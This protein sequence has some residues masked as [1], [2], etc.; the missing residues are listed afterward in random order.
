MRGAASQN[1][2][3]M[4]LKMMEKI[5]GVAGNCWRTGDQSTA[6]QKMYFRPETRG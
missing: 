4:L 3:I 2:F 6:S 1:L 5:M